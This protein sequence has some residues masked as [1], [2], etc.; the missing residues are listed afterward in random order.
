MRKFSRWSYGIWCWLM[1]L[2]AVLTSLLV[3]VPAPRISQRRAVVRFAA[4]TY[5]WTTATPLVLRGLERLPPGPCVVVANHASYIDGLVMHAALPPRFAFVIKSEMVKVPLANVLLRRLGSEFVDRIDR[6]RAAA[7]VRRVVRTASQGQ[8]LAV[9]PEGTFD[10][11]IGVHRFLPGA[12]TAAARA[13]LPV[14]PA[15]IRGA[16]DVFPYPGWLARR[17]TIEVEFL[18]VLPAA[19]H[20]G[21]AAANE[22]RDAA[23]AAIIAAL[24]EP[25]LAE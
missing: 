3:G 14:V 8:A 21:R 13:G 2:W 5:L 18:D 11:R 20:G 17:G 12:F 23:R 22:L 7:D 15:A 24:G 25:D 16:R 1:F 10:E 4:R 6:H 19:P 9:F